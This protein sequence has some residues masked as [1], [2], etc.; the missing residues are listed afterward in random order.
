MAERNS[1]LKKKK[2]VHDAQIFLLKQNSQKKKLDVVVLIKKQL[3]ELFAGAQN[4][5]SD[6]PAINNA[7]NPHFLHMR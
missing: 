5:T 7:Q 6:L 2:N 3:L 1:K 4:L